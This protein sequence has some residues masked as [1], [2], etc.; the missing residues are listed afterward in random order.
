[1]TRILYKAQCDDAK[2]TE[3]E[4]DYILIIRKDVTLN[5]NDNEVR[6]IKY[7]NENELSEMAND[8]NVLISPWFRILYSSGRIN[9][10]W[11]IL[12]AIVNNQYN[13]DEGIHDF[14]NRKMT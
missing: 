7:C 11:S 5:L 12:N 1:M 14:Y 10:W 6:D 8:E 13:I 2:W 3:N 4:L 9:E